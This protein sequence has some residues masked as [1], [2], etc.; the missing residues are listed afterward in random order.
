MEPF[1]VS[2]LLIGFSSWFVA[3][4]LTSF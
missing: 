2:T 4:K 1:S 3:V